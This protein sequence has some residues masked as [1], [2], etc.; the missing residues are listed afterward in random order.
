MDACPKCQ[1]ILPKQAV[2][3]LFCGQ[4]GERVS[5]SPQATDYRVGEMI[6]AFIFFMDAAEESL[7]KLQS[8][9]R[10]CS[11][12]SPQASAE[13]LDFL[14][15]WQDSN[16]ILRLEFKRFVASPTLEKGM[17]LVLLVAKYQKE[18]QPEIDRLKELI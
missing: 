6:R 15:R 17:D 10:T 2:P 18:R 7:A 3:H 1:D 12:A 8:F 16:R 9:W 11:D 4:C 5:G 14:N 13:A